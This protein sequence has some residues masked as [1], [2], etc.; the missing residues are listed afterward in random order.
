MGERRKKGYDKW[1]DYAGEIYDLYALAGSET[2]REDLI[3]V[4]IGHTE[5]YEDNFKKRWRLK[6]GGAKLTK[7]NVEGKLSY[8]LYSHIEY[9]NKKPKYYFITQSD[10]TTTAR[11][12]EGCF[13]FQIDNDLRHVIDSIINYEN[14]EEIDEFGV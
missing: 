4:F 8:T 9:E 10:G 11:S 1:L 13:D 12:P 3:V 2:L 6:T 14:S 5:I 7:L